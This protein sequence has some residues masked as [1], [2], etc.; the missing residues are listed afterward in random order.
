LISVVQ[1][2]KTKNWDK[3]KDK[4]K[5]MRWDHTGKDE[6]VKLKKKRGGWHIHVVKDDQLIGRSHSTSKD[7]ARKKAVQWMRDHP[8]G[9]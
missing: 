7:K 1:R 3:T 6:Y 4:R 2:G 9:A 5:L 8:H